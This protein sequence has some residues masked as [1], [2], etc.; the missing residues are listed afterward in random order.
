[1]SISPL[2]TAINASQAPAS[3]QHRGSGVVSPPLVESQ[4]LY[5]YVTPS[6]AVSLFVAGAASSLALKWFLK[7]FSLPKWMPGKS[8]KPANQAMADLSRRAERVEDQTA[9]YFTEGLPSVLMFAM[10]NP[11]QVQERLKAYLGASVLGYVLGSV[12]DGFQEVWIRREE[13]QIRADLINRLTH[14]FRQSI[15]YKEALDNQ[16]R[17]TAKKRIADILTLC[18]IPQPEALL[19]PMPDVVQDKLYRYPYEPYHFSKPMASV[20]AGYRFG[21]AGLTPP[22]PQADLDPWHL[23]AIKAGFYGL[24]LLTGSLGQFMVAM[25]QQAGRAAGS[26]SLPQSAQRIFYRIFN[27]SNVEAMFLTGSGQVLMTILGLTAAAKVG[28]MLIDGYR[29]IEVTRQNAHTEWRYQAHNWLALDPAFHRIAEEEALEA[30][31]RK[32]TAA[33]PYEFHNRKV[34]NK[35]IQ[36]ILTNIGRNSAPKYFQMTPPVNLVAARS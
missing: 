13:T 31:L 11:G 5:H 22:G 18:N 36:T 7:G 28:K 30:S 8:S 15:Q 29:E 9:V 3:V 19:E 16:L 24:G 23:R 4:R 20:N 1:M 27:V 17:E 2:L 34:L 6:Q 33:I 21:Q 14:N 26:N 32:L 25:L 35:R 10:K 12:A